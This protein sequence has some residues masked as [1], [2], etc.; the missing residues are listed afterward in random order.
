VSVKGPEPVP[1]FVDMCDESRIEGA[2]IFIA[3]Y[4][5]NFGVKLYVN[6]YDD[7]LSDRGEPDGNTSA[8]PL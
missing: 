6:F 8:A 1:T 3:I 7:T 2:S 4:R 5:S